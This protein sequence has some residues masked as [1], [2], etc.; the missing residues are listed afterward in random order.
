[1]SETGMEVA[2]TAEDRQVYKA[3]IDAPIEVVWNTLVKTD[4]V[5]P[6]FFGAVCE[7]EDAALKPGACVARE[8]DV[9]CRHRS[10]LSQ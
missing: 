5:L 7:A 6:F 2:G 10:F 8:F 4:E 9:F 1:M 3:M